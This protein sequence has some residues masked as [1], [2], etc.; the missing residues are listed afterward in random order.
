MKTPT[1]KLW[2][3]DP[4]L[5][6]YPLWIPPGRLASLHHYFCPACGEVWAWFEALDS[7]YH[8]H[9]AS[10]TLCPKHGGGS[11]NLY[12]NYPLI[13]LSVELLSREIEL[14]LA[15]GDHYDYCNYADSPAYREA[16]ARALRQAR[17]QHAPSW[18]DWNWEDLFDSHLP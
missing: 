5:E 10:H 14:I 16:N 6:P 9:R 18:R 17:K 3:K 7:D 11:L 2:I 4:E 8:P 13:H 12:G 15:Y 1:H